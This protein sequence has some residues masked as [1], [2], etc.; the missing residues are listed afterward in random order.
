MGC[1]A[2][3]LNDAIRAMPMQ[4]PTIRQAIRQLKRNWFTAKLDLKSGFQLI[5]VHKHFVDLLGFK[6]PDGR[7]ARTDIW[8]SGQKAV[9]SY[10]TEHKKNCGCS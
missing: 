9:R 10:S 5:P 1:T 3:G 7:F 6:H 4:L 2:N 8:R